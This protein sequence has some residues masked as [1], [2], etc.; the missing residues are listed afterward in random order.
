M[1][2]ER[3]TDVL[4]AA[5]RLMKTGAAVRVLV[6]RSE[7]Q[8]C[9]WCESQS[10]GKRRPTSQLKLSGG[11]NSVFFYLWFYPSPDGLDDACP[12]QGGLYYVYWLKC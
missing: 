5:W 11:E 6:L 2:P 3:S 12:H 1:E 10:E 7:N 8:E 9:W 4:S